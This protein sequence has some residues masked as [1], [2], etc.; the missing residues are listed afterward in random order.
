MTSRLR[1]DSCFTKRKRL[2]V[3]NGEE[4]HFFLQNHTW[5]LVK[6]PSGK[7][8]VKCKLVFQL[9]TNVDGVVQCDKTRLVVKGCF[10]CFGFDFI[11]TYSFMVHSES[12]STLFYLSRQLKIWK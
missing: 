6:L 3:G 7:R 1:D 2:E 4:F 9:K 5:D 12:R 10:Q 8:V 11:E